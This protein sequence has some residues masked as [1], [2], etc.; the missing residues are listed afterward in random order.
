[1]EVLIP[2]FDLALTADSGQ[3]FRFDRLESDRW[4]VIA[5]GQVLE[6]QALGEDRFHLSCDTSA[7]AHTWHNYLDLDRDYRAILALISPEDTYLQVAASYA[8]GLR[9]LRQDPWETLISFIISQRKNM[10]AIKGC[11]AKLSTLYGT[12]LGEGLYA[13]PA[14][15]Q[16]AGLDLPALNAC[17]LGYRSRYIQ[18]TARAMAEGAVSLT[19]MAALDDEALQKE[20]CSLSGVGIKVAQCV[21]LFAYQRMDAFPRDVWID[22]VLREQYPQGFPLHLY[23]G[24]AGI[25]QQ[26]LFCYRRHIAGRNA[27]KDAP[28]VSTSKD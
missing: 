6:I 21:M 7:Y 19:A 2:G 13:F 5:K 14:P 1:M 15:G 10:Q 12:S 26:Q 4:R 22:R 20:L 17:G 9:L 16:L 27:G 11:V 8:G 23:P 3:C 18:A 25:L 28:T 24:C